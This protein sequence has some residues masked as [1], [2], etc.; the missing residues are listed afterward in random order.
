MHLHLSDEETA[1]E[2]ASAN[3]AGGA[4]PEAG[5]DRRL[6]RLTKLAEGWPSVADGAPFKKHKQSP[7]FYE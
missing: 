5:L 4:T 3:S 6:Y 7:E 1:S 2:S